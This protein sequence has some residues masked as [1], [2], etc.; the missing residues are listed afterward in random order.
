MWLMRCVALAGMNR[1]ANDHDVSGLYLMEYDVEAFDGAGM[2]R[3]TGDPAKALQF[4]NAG[5]VHR[6]WTQQS[7]TTPTRDDGR[8]NRPL[9]AYTIEAIRDVDARPV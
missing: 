6:T 4:D 9:T 8:P 1:A 2:A 7:T 3:W 5:D